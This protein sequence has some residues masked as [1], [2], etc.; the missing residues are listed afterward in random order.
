MDGPFVQDRDLLV[1]EPALLRDAGWAGQRVLDVT[2]SVSGGVLTLASGSFS[3]AGVDAGSV[4]L[5]DGLAVEVVSVASATAASV[6]LLRARRDGASVPPPAATN[7]PVRCY[8]FGPQREIVHR[9]VL[10]MAGIDPDG[11]GP[12]QDAITN[13]GA[14]VRLEALGVLHLVYAAASAPGSGGAALADR[15][16]MYRERFAA[17]RGRV[18][19]LIDADGDGI[20]ETRRSL[21]VFH[22]VRG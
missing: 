1:L 5:I 11:D 13:P 19:A 14:L 9:Q 12:G 7:R 4:L 22:M 21:S 2:G 20:A 10:A 15:A 18:A 8:A 6:S 3:D 17:E 16:A